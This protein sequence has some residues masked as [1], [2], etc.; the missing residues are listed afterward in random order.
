MRSLSMHE[1]RE[2]MQKFG[3][4]ALKGRSVLSEGAET[5]LTRPGTKITGMKKKLT[6]M[7]NH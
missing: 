3:H 7:G 2:I 5:V 1:S 4:E 6:G